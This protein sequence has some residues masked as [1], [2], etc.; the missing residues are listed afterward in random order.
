VKLL[1]V[2]SLRWQATL[3]G[4]PHEVSWLSFHADGQ[5]LASAG[6][7]LV[8]LWDIASRK[9]IARLR[10]HAPFPGLVGSVRGVAFNASGNLIT[11]TFFQ[12]EVPGKSQRTQVRLWDTGAGHTMPS[13]R[14]A[15]NGEGAVRLGAFSR[16]SQTLV[17]AVGGDFV[18]WNCA[19]GK[20]LD[21]F[22]TTD[23]KDYPNG[24]SVAWTN[25]GGLAGSVV[26]SWNVATQE[27]EAWYAYLPLQVR[28]RK[29]A[30]SRDGQLLVIAQG[31]KPAEIQV[32]DFRSGKGLRRFTGHTKP[33]MTLAFAEDCRMLASGSMDGSVILWDA[34]LGRRKTTLEGHTATVYSLAISPDG[35]IVASG[36][37]DGTI[38]FWD[39]GSGQELASARGHTAT[40]SSLAFSPDG[41]TLASASWDGT[42][43]LWEPT[44]G[45]QRATLMGH[46]GWVIGV[47]FSPDGQTLA[48]AGADRSIRLWQAQ[49]PRESA[50]SPR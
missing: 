27:K 35:K 40:V 5:M 50:R 47:M 18:V 2:A 4:H 39:A 19:T 29:T 49:F 34:A 1:D 15:M 9:E 21:T 20:K 38:K 42:I 23:N 36:S 22:P 26:K 8:K 30:L 46:D 43:V 7:A 31:G 28:G 37:Y 44:T 16:D 12:S 32:A 17:T 33:V 6:G 48:S 25:R 3:G 24:L 14:L 41:K 11:A 10:S 45:Q 13:R